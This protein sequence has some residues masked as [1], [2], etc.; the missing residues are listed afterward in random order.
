MEYINGPKISE[1][2]KIEKMGIDKK[3]VAKNLINIFSTMIFKH[4]YVHCDAHP[5]N[6]LIRK[7]PTAPM[8]H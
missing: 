4:G 3:K 8:G 7:K 5:G 1:P 6:L 2:E